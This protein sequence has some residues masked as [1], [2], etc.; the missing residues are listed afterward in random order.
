MGFETSHFDVD[1]VVTFF[2]SLDGSRKLLLSEVCT[3]GRLLLVMPATNAVSE[4]SFSALKQVKT[5]DQQP[6]IPDLTI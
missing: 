2:Q 3:L 1:D 5:Y 6:V 4:R